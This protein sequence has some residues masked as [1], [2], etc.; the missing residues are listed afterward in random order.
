MKITIIIFLSLIS[1]SLAENVGIKNF[2]A[3][4]ASGDSRSLCTA[5]NDLRQEAINE[6]VVDASYDLD[7]SDA[8]KEALRRVQIML[9]PI[10]PDLIR[11][12]NSETWDTGAAAAA[13]LRYSDGD[14][15]VYVCLKNS[16]FS[17]V[18]HIVKSTLLSLRELKLTNKETKAIEIERL[19]EYSENPKAPFMERMYAEG[20]VGAI[21]QDAQIWPFPEAIPVFI[22]FLDSS[23]YSVGTKKMVVKCLFCM[24]ADA[25]APALPSV[26]NERD[27]LKAANGKP[28]DL[29]FFDEAVKRMVKR[30]E[31]KQSTIDVKSD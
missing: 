29:A 24:T 17:E 3:A 1:F 23:E 14:E 9:D 22:K 21:L 28:E 11:L 4:L 2:R 13:L 18:P 27:R 5:I 12:V 16:L 6:T 15:D 20:V 26:I 10:K 7:P 30:S 8:K 19:N 31:V 25:S